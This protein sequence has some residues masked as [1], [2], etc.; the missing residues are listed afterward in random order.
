MSTAADLDKVFHDPSSV[1]IEK[2]I[3]EVE[4]G[5]ISSDDQNNDAAKVA[6]AQADAKPADATAKLPGEQGGTP[7][8]SADA[9]TQTAE[10][11]GV[12]T[13][14]GKNVIP[15][16][17]L[18]NERERA[19]QAERARQEAEQRAALA[20]QSQAQLQ[21]QIAAMQAQL[22]A[23]LAQP[24][25][26]PKTTAAITPEM[27][28]Q[29]QE[30]APGVLAI[31]DALA[32]Q[33]AA[34]GREAAA[35]RADAARAKEVVERQQAASQE[36]VAETA[37]ANNPKLS[38]LRSVNPNAFNDFVDIDDV[39]RKQAWA[40]NLSIGERLA[41]TV[42]MYEAVHGRIEFPGAPSAAPG[43]T[44][45]PATAAQ[46]AIARA[47]AAPATGAPTTLSDIP[48]GATPPKSEAE[49]LSQLSPEQLMTKMLSMDSKAIDILLAQ[50]SI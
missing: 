3:A 32:D 26:P 6:T 20:T 43:K 44:T 37:I 22:Q 33:L 15:Y 31:F 28:Q 24:A 47:K 23:G 16:L 27:R 7:A 19:A 36:E 9:T 25:S 35:A 18:A 8:T 2:L 41:K 38:Y 11:V 49:A 14:D 1:D 46:A 34:A 10:P 39:A 50:T 4:G 21:A 48:G 42:E 29:L 30:E 17:V 12:L 13:K 5:D 45:D 40:K